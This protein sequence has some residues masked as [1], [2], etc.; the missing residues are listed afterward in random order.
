MQIRPYSPNDLN[1]LKLILEK[2]Y[3]KDNLPDFNNLLKPQVVTDDDNTIVSAGGIELIPEGVLITNKDKS[4]LM[5]G[6]ALKLQLSIMSATCHQFGYSDLHAFVS[7]DD[8]IWIRAL[9]LYDFQ[10]AGTAF[11][12]R[13]P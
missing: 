11:F 4:E 12:K 3:P 8:P 13:I 5:R 6:R 10:S 2:Y 1:E 7:D 9:K